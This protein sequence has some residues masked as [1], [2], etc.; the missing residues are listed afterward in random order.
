MAIER[1]TALLLKI[2]GGRAG[3]VVEAVHEQALPRR[4]WIA[5]RRARLARVLDVR[6][7][8]GEVVRILSALGLAVESTADGWRALSPSWR[9]DLAIE[10]DLIEEV[11]RIH[12]YEHVPARAPRG[13]LRIPALPEARLG[14]AALRTQLVAR[15]YVEAV[16]YAC[17]DGGVLHRWKLAEG[18]LALAN[19][20]SADLAVMR[21]SLLPGL[22]AALAMNRRRQQARVR[23]FEVGNVFHAGADGPIETLRIAGVV[24]GAAT[25]EQWGQSRRAV[26]FFDVKGDVDAL[27]ALTNAAHEF[28]MDTGAP[29]YLHPGQA[30]AYWRGD[31]RVGSL[32]AL[33]PDLLKALDLDEDVFV[34]ELDVAVIVPRAL[35]KAAPISRFPSVRRDLSFELPQS[36]PY[37]QVEAAIR[38]AVGE[39][40]AGIVLFDRYQGKNLGSEIKSLA[41]GLI[42]QDT[43]RTLTDQ[44]ADRCTQL[45]VAALERDCQAKLRG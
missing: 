4:E 25:A 33:H 23:L 32:G 17:L 26:D 40:L 29:D 34:F 13:E 2:A 15:E 38:G 3:P 27:F 41:M 21:T 10:E 44:D 7:D 28:R 12:G 24:C 14:I 39:T 31:R 45:A 11:V 37:A 18:A 20:L 16:C 35:P 8:D 30:A 42:L 6:I 22:V 36:V 1:A 19:P 5:L 9:F 43:S